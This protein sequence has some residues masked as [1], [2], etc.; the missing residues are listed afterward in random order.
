MPIVANEKRRVLA[1]GASDS[2]NA[3]LPDL[4]HLVI[5]RIGYPN[6][7]TPPMFALINIRVNNADVK[8]ESGWIRG[9]SIASLGDFV[10][11]D[12][13][14]PMHPAGGNTIRWNVRNDTGATNTF[15]VAWVVE[16]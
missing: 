12:G 11:L 4:G 7:S 15:T 5:A 2:D 1:T 8:M 9:P 10:V 6:A 13:P 14:V 3:E 16:V